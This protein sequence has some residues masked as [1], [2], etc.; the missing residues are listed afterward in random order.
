MSLL[1]CCIAFSVFTYFSSAIDTYVAGL[2]Y[3]QQIHLF[4]GEMHQWVELIYS[5]VPYITVLI[6]VL[7]IVGI[8]Y[9]IL[10]K[11]NSVKKTSII[12]ILAL[13]IGPGL[14]VNVLFKDYWGRARPY[15]VLRDYQKYTPFYIPQIKHPK[16]NSFPSGHASIGFFLGVP[17][18]ALKRRKLGLIISIGAG[19]IIGMVRILQGGHY[20]S[21]VILAFVIS[22]LIAEL[23]VYIYNYYFDE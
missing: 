13:I 15:Q 22:W 7:S 17:F 18:L 9:G 1:Y 19:C 14:F 12:V 3:N 6:I 11:N 16:N 8:L 2:F 4:Y 21:D 10:N 23:I 20:V 5:V